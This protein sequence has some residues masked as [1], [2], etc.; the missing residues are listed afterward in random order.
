MKKIKTIGLG[1]LLFGIS[2]ITIAQ[3]D[4]PVLNAGATIRQAY[5]P[6]TEIK[7]APDFTITD[8]D[9]T[10]IDSFSIQISSGY[11]EGSDRLELKGTYTAINPSWSAAE[12]KL[13]LTSAVVGTQISYTELQSAVREVVFT[14]SSNTISGEKY[15][16][17]TIGSANYLPSNQHFY[18]FEPYLDITWTKA[19][20]EAE[21][22]GKKYYG[23]QGYLATILSD[24]ESQ[25]SAEQ[26][27]GAGWIG[28]SDEDN[29]GVWKW[30]TGPE[31][32]TIF[33]NGKGTNNGGSAPID[34]VTGNP[35]YS[36]WS[37]SEEP[38]DSGNEDYAHIKENASTWNDLKNEGG[39]PTGGQYRAKG[40]IVEYG[41]TTGDPVL[42]ISASTSIYVPEILTI[43]ADKDV[44]TGTS[45]NLTA[46]VTEGT[47]F[48]YD[49]SG[50]RVHEGNSYTTPALNSSITYYASAS[51]ADCATSDR[52]VVVIT[53]YGLPITNIP[54]DIIDCDDNKDGFN[55]FD[56]SKEKDDEILQSNL[57]P[58]DF[59]VLYFDTFT[60]A[61]NNV[62][63]SNLPNPYKVN[64]GSSQTI[65]ARVHNKNDNTCFNIVDFDI[66]VTGTPIPKTPLDYAFCD[67]TSVGSDTDGFVNDFVLENKDAEILGTLDPN[68]YNVSY[69]TTQNGAQTNATLDAIPKTTN[70]TNTTANTQPVYVRVENVDNA[71]CFDASKSFNLVVNKL[72]ILKTNPELEQCI[73]A[74][75]NSPTVNL[76]TA[77]VNI[78][79][80]ANVTFDYFENITA[81]TQITDPTSYPVI[82]N[83]SQTVF[84]RVTSE[85]GCPRDLIGL[86]IN[87]GQT[88]DN[89][90]NEIQTPV[91]DDFLD[92]DGNDSAANNDTD[93][94]TNFSLDENAITTSI[95]PPVNTI[96]YFYENAEDRNNTLNEIDIT[97][98]RNDINRIDITTIASGIQFPI[99]YKIL[100]TINNDCQG[101]GQFYLQINAVPKANTL[102]PILECDTGAIDGNYTNGSNRNIDLTQRI[103]ELFI[104]TN[105]DQNDYDVTFYKSVTAAFS[106]D[107]S[108]S[109]YID[110]PAQFTNDVPNGFSVG[111]IVTQSIFVR[112]QN[113][114]TGCAN[115][116][117]SF[118][119][120]I[121]SIPIIT[122]PIPVLEV[123]DIGTNDGDVR[124][125]LAQ[126]IDVSI[127]DI[128]IIGTRI[129]TDF[130]ITYHKTR[131]DAEDL[132]STGIDK[133]SYDSDPTRV[134]INPTTN[135]S[136]ESLLIRIVDNNSGCVFDQSTLTIIV[137]PEPDF[138]TISNLSECDNDDD[139]DDANQIIQT[140]DLDGKITEI[141]GTSQDPDDYIVTF[142]A[143][144][145]SATSGEDAISSPYTNTDP[146]ETIF[147]RIQNKATLC[148]NDSAT[149]DIIVNSLPNFM[150]TSPQIICLNDTPKNISIENPEAI[151]NYI[152]K[153]ANNNEI[154][155]ED[156]LNITI[157]GNYTVTATTTDGT[158]CSRIETIV[159]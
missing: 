39:G 84:V 42:N 127:R 68:Q 144:Q 10:G 147:V 16:S 91:C 142:H 143:T 107:I 11:S 12:G 92:A 15:F 154:S 27:S 95:N 32:G 26:I 118:Q 99:Y 140:I 4:A 34:P 119:V 52:K 22:P 13:K 133:N 65:F 97:D 146:T 17:L 33:W 131:A 43:S 49:A 83:T 62:T 103:D 60:K 137:N 25:I 47:I 138:E 82:V 86:T 5:C 123:C 100:S 120:I 48:W 53:V 156:N 56:L 145:A 50:N 151:Y 141:L 63:G 132:S 74:I 23:L 128:D 90:Y 126:N 78:S 46:T 67:N 114:A 71:A 18:V 87:V 54:S 89:P 98:Y 77:Q 139:G 116:H 37:G 149:F 80:T 61:T 136:E 21:S 41:G 24:E 59:E 155:A 31:A 79:E 14:S 153:D 112:V 110:T 106:G 35:M 64:T 117:T 3:N 158:N 121:N 129:S 88:P 7:I 36:N 104:G 125:G 111:D 105:Q 66:A 124:N 19:K 72:P 30:V 101:I 73:S 109:D 6:Q 81:T 1:I 75:D 130:K 76:T 40:Y 148:I 135:I 115:P 38:N 44:C 93:F 20:E 150:V 58:S 29:E 55:E 159:I 134:T 51:P 28:G 122:N 96:V 9:D 113:K 8:A 94:I 102:S 57:T 108:S 85:F 152:W 69:H 45:V 70:Y 157:G 2:T